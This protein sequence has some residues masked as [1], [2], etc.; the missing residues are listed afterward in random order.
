[1]IP[2]PHNNEVGIKVACDADDL[3]RYVPDSDVSLSLEACLT[4]TLHR[5]PGSMDHCGGDID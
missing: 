1:M 4:R 2:C 5:V 3:L